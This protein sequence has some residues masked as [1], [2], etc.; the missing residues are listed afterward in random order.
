MAKFVKNRHIWARNYFIFL[1]NVIN[2]VEILLTPN[3]NLSERLGKAV[4]NALFCDLI[5]LILS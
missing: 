4:T 3:F 5:A 2:K 1:K